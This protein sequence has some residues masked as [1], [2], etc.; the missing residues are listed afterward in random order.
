MPCLSLSRLKKCSRPTGIRTL[1][2]GQVR[3]EYPLWQ[4][5]TVHSEYPLKFNLRKKNARLEKSAFRLRFFS[6]RGR[7]VANFRNKSDISAFRFIQSRKFPL[8]PWAAFPLLWDGRFPPEH[9]PAGF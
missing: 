7:I 8:P 5:Q 9:Y 2:F 3:P 1:N 6:N 4:Y